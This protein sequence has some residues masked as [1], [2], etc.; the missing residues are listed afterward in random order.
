MRVRGFTLIELLVVIAIIAILIALLLPAVQQAREA[1]RRT[2]CRNNLH[3]IGL[4]LHNYHDTH[5]MFPPGEINGAAVGCNTSLSCH[6]ASV[7]VLILPYLDGSAV[8]N[9]YN[10]SRACR[11]CDG[12]NSTA[13]CQKLSQYACL[14]MGEPELNTYL[15]D[16]WCTGHYAYCSGTTCRQ[17]GCEVLCGRAR[18]CGGGTSFLRRAESQDCSPSAGNGY[19]VVPSNRHFRRPG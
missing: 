2:Q 4:A 8:Y 18:L 15:A 3:Q 13:T 10:F 9:A 6:M 16:G 11:Y 12:V 14:S 1:A 17:H 19:G 5:S 7:F